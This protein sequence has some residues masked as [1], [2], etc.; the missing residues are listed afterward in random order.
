MLALTA[1]AQDINK[2]ITFL[3]QQANGIL[4]LNTRTFPDVTTWKADIQTK[5][6]DA[7]GVTTY[8]TKT[9][10][11]LGSAYYMKMDKSY[12][13]GSY[14]ITVNGMDAR[15]RV[16]TTQGPEKI[17]PNWGQNNTCSWHCVGR[18]YAFQIDLVPGNGPGISRFEVVEPVPHNGH[19]Y[20]YQ[21][22]KASDWLTYASNPNPA[23]AHYY[24]LDNFDVDYY[25]S[26][27]II[28]QDDVVGG[29]PE[30]KDEDGFTIT[31]GHVYGLRKYFGQWR[32]VYPYMKSNELADGPDHLCQFTYPFAEAMINNADDHQTPLLS[33]NGDSWGDY[34][35][36][37]ND[38]IEGDGGDNDGFS[39]DCI[40]LLAGIVFSTGDADVALAMFEV[41]EGCEGFATNPGGSGGG[42]VSW[43]SAVGSITFE[44]Y[45]HTSG[46]KPVVLTETSM[47]DAS[48]N[49][50]GKPFTITSGLNHMVI[51]FKN[52]HYKRA[53]FIAPK[54]RKIALTQSNFVTATAFPVP[55]TGNDFTMEFK[56]T[57]NESFTYVLSDV[58]GTILFRKSYTIQKGQDLRDA[59]SVSRGIPSGMLFN[60][61]QFGDGSQISFQTVK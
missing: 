31:D 25:G 6:T 47:L 40:D 24:G 20:Y 50:I 49:Y 29:Q 22:I 60:Q 39:N 34:D 3:P 4:V 5:S 12:M 37:P 59:I 2:P 43:P 10:V 53:Y 41:M 55:I 8:S 11:N 52:G 19:P 48:G 13:D 42:H 14:Y 58:N 16:V 44:P 9:T 45:V 26:Q 51:R 7:H 57:A 28:I 56:A 46:V 23:L 30:I 17:D 33:C 36:D 61:L 27:D 54:D 32:G 18:D 1:A 38:P 21:W 15:G 35:S